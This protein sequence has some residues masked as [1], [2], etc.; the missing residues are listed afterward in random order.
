M[1]SNKKIWLVAGA[2]LVAIVAIIIYISASGSNSKSAVLKVNGSKVDVEYVLKIQDEEI[3]L[4]GYRYYFFSTKYYYDN[5]D[6]NFWKTESA[7]DQ[8]TLLKAEVLES[9]K[10][11][12]IMKKLARENGCELIESDLQFIDESVNSQI[13]ELGGLSKYHEALSERYMTDEI[14]REQWQL[15]LYYDKL[16]NFY[17][18]EGGEF[19]NEKIDS[20]D[21]AV[22]EK[23]YAIL[24][25]ILSERAAELSVE[26]GAEYDLITVEALS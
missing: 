21:D 20:D 18:D 1:G 14:F 12:Y 24:D 5:G 8:E 2:L 6:E 17:F 10:E 25:R 9:L 19:Y 3:D 7:E 16:Y 22:K 23:N 13:E 4:D 15:T 26:Y 11:A